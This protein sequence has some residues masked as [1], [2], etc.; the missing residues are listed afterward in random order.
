MMSE[1]PKKGPVHLNI[2]NSVLKENINFDEIL[3]QE[4][5]CKLPKKGKKDSNNYKI[6]S[7]DDNVSLLQ[8]YE[9]KYEELEELEELDKE[10]KFNF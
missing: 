10:L 6:I 3:L 7:E 1:F 8:Y 5:T 2:C 9:K 4:P